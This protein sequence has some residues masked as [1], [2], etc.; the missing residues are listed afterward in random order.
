MAMTESSDLWSG[1][2][3]LLGDIKDFAL[4]YGRAKY[5][6][7]ETTQSDRNIPDEADL[8]EGYAPQTA[9]NATGGV[10]APSV[11]GVDV[12]QVALIGG[13]GLLGLVVLKKA[14]VF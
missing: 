4:D 10:Y 14:K 2:K 9:S 8:R 12:K 11:A 6:D 3:N 13:L 5:I 7:V 1:A